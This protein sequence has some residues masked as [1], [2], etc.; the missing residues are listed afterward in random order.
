MMLLLVPIL[1][2]FMFF[3]YIKPSKIQNLV[4]HGNKKVSGT[5]ILFC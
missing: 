5:D 2:I 1:N 4:K 3:K